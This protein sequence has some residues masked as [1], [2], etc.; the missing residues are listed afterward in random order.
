MLFWDTAPRAARD[1]ERAESRYADRR[2][3]GESGLYVSD[4]LLI[5][6]RNQ[7]LHCRWIPRLISP[8]FDSLLFSL[9]TAA[10]GALSLS[11]RKKDGPNAIDSERSN[12]RY[13]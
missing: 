10:G 13:Q 3:G 8:T 7:E 1:L 11:V 9:S 2:R 5:F 6:I 12:I 4:S